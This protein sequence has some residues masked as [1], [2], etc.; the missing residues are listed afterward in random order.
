MADQYSPH[1]QAVLDN[2]NI[3]IEVLA[4][5]NEDAL[6][7]FLEKHFEYDNQRYQMS[8]ERT[9]PDGT[10]DRKF[11]VT[12]TAQ[13]PL[14][15][16]LPPFSSA[17]R[18]DVEAA[19]RQRMFRDE[20]GWDELLPP[21]PHPTLYV[22]EVD[23]PEDPTSSQ[24]KPN[25]RLWCS[26]LNVVLTWPRLDGQRPDWSFPFTVNLLAEAWV[27][28][29][30]SG[31]K[32]YLRV[33]PIRIKFDKPVG[34]FA[35]K[36]AKKLARERALTARDDAF[37]LDECE[38]KF[39][40]LIVIALNVVANQVA[41][42]LVQNVQLPVPNIANKPL[43]PVLLDMSDKIVTVGCSLDRE[44]IVAETRKKLTKSFDIYKHLLEEDIK[45][46]GGLEK[47]LCRASD[48]GD[49]AIGGFV[50]RPRSEIHARLPRSRAYLETLSREVN[51]PQRSSRSK[52]IKRR[53]AV[54]DG[55]CVGVNEYF[56][57]VVASSLLPE[58]KADCTEWLPLGVVRGRACY[59]VRLYSPT[60]DIVDRTVSGQIGVDVGGALEGCVRK[61]WDCS[62]RWACEQLT[63]ALRG[64]PG[65]QLRLLSGDAGVR[66]K[67]KII[68][69]LTLESNL[70]FPFDKV[71]EAIGD[72]VWDGVKVIL[73]II[74]GFL[75]IEIVPPKIE[76]PEQKTKLTLSGFTS[77]GFVRAKPARLDGA[78]KRFIAYRTGLTASR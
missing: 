78:R 29:K 70:P 73:N 25:L 39:Y 54:P 27:S 40:D 37:L 42:Q 33:V 9:V 63:L 41:P 57:N 60:I 45:A 26:G 21:I 58:P 66:L 30:Q 76:F 14:R 75:E 44:T 34:S 2:T 16:E 8:F 28:L 24:G 48:R 74:L 11:T 5:I 68:G 19:R 3:S 43:L 13:Q 56:L 12:V 64:H 51:P 31:T 32:F 62:W 50:V 47:V 52:T 17:K 1:W 20:K 59:W 10:T 55:A 18:G 67:A 7:H 77:V 71:V 15:A 4:S 49:P 61:F 53:P 69:E 35:K 23:D 36:A 72:L 6:N 22:P 38:Q 46:A 65:L